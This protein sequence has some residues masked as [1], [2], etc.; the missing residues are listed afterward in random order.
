MCVYLA[1]ILN[2]AKTKN[3]AGGSISV[4]GNNHYVLLV[5]YAESTDVK[6]MATSFPIFQSLLLGPTNLA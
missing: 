1:L 2:S 5:C 4:Q 3:K 6:Y